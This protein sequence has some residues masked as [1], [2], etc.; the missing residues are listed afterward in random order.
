MCSEGA[1]VEGVG[2]GGGSSLR[3]SLPYGANGAACW[4]LESPTV[5]CV[6]AEGEERE[7]G[8]WR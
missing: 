6:S 5:T 3:A 8:T 7:R 1:W 4:Q 2:G